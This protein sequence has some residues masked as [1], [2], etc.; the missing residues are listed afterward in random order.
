M[1]FHAAAIGLVS[2]HRKKEFM[3]NSS[4]NGTILIVDDDPNIV[5]L[6]S[7]NLGSE[8]FGTAVVANAEEV[9][10]D[11]VQDMRLVIADNMNKPY[12]GL[13]LLRDIKATT[14]VPVIICTASESEDTVIRAFD[15]GADDFVEKPF[16]LRELVA[17]IRAVLRRHPQRF[18][19]EAAAPRTTLKFDNIGL[20]ID[21]ESQRVTISGTAIPLTKTEY[22]ILLYLVRNRNSFFNRNEICEEIWRDETM[23]NARIVDTNISRLRKKLGDAGRYIIN[24]YGLGYAFTDNPE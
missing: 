10:L 17:R 5:E 1:I 16:S 14:P 24:R 20:T 22:Q 11:K 19:Q 18:A 23:T 9:D 2:N 4:P 12:S 13:D 6:L 7:F 15:A 3:F 21:I 8:G